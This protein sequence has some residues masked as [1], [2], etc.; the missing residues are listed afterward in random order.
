MRGDAG[1][2]ALGEPLA[3]TDCTLTVVS[4][5]W[6]SISDTVKKRLTE[7]TRRMCAGGS[8]KLS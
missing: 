2:L 3:A 4:L 6:N 5:L 8:I 1:A 7:Q